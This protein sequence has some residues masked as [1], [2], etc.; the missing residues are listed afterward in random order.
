[1]DRSVQSYQKF[2][3]L[4]KLRKNVAYKDQCTTRKAQYM[5]PELFDTAHPTLHYITLVIIIFINI[6]I[7]I[8]IMITV[9]TITF[10]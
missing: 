9:I 8:N 4:Y 5:Q 3:L 2:L 1:M 6:T 10:S 7:I